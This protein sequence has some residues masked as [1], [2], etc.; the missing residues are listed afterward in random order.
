MHIC[1][2]SAEKIVFACQIDISAV[3][4]LQFTAF[5]SGSTTVW[6]ADFLCLN[7]KIVV[8]LCAR[9]IN[10]P[11]RA[12]NMKVYKLLLTFEKIGLLKPMSR[13]GLLPSHL[14]KWMDIY[15]FSM[16]HPDMSYV[17][18]SNNFQGA[19]KSTIG[20]ALSFMNQEIMWRP[21]IAVRKCQKKAVPLHRNS[22]KS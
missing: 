8:S 6:A 13:V 2:F 11:L 4:K 7:R 1:K 14:T 16:E 3:E 18:V 19:T 5:F 22:R 10:I 21:A 15:A 12:Y 9:R 20:R 17:E